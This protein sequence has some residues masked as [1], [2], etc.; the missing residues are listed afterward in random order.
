M[1]QMYLAAHARDLG[2]L[3]SFLTRA[4]D[5][6]TTSDWQWSSESDLP[7]LAN[8]MQEMGR[9]SCGG[10]AG[11]VIVVILVVVDVAV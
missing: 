7:A 11:I 3:T 8:K 1:L 5:G 9:V 4:S 2:G 6:P 10:I